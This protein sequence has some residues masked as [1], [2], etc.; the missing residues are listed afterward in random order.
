MAVLLIHYKRDK[1]EI[2]E[3][4]SFEI[5]RLDHIP[6]FP[7]QT[8]DPITTLITSFSQ[9]CFLKMLNFVE[10]IVFNEVM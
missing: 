6:V 4:F 9:S 8:E 3:G 2:E 5:N 7:I 10:F 1:W